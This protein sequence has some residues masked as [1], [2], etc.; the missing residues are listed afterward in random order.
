MSMF[1]LDQIQAQIPQAIVERYKDRPGD[2]WGVI[3]REHIVA[4]VKLLKEKLGFRLFV[5]MDAVDRKQK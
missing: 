3:A 1:A 4:V 2:A 5:S